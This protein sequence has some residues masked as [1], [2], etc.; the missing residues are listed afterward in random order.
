MGDAKRRLLVV[1]H[2]GCD[3]CGRDAELL[4]AFTTEE[5]AKEHLKKLYEKYSKCYLNAKLDMLYFSYLCIEANT[6]M[7]SIEFC[8]FFD[9]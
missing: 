5:A 9:K 3:K 2:L 4:C 7:V 6:H 8:P 1:E